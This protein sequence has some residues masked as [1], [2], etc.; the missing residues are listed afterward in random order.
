MP[1]PLDYFT[2]PKPPKFARLK[3]VIGVTSAVLI[4]VILVVMLVALGLFV[5]GIYMGLRRH[6]G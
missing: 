1:E 4:V 3:T 6:G 2:P 5:L